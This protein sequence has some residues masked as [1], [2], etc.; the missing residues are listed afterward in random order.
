MSARELLGVPLA[1]AGLLFLLLAIASPVL[2]AEQAKE[3]AASLQELRAVEGHI[4]SLAA[5]HREVPSDEVLR[6]W[7]EARGLSIAPSLSTEP[8]GC[9]N[10]FQKP[11]NDKF[12][13]GY[14]AGEWSECYSSPS[15][16]T[17][18]R[19]TAMG[20]LS[21]GL[22]TDI[23]LYILLAF[24]LGGTAWML[25]RRPAHQSGEPA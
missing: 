19:P 7:A 12:V 16:A 17:T 9:L 2:I 11:K 4:A 25:L 13:V 23:A 1:L 21:S 18:L 5:R 10:G 8:L 22:G 6:A 15:G 3:D 24:A 14:W 20:L